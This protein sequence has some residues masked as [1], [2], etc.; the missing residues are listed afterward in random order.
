MNLVIMISITYYYFVIKKHFILREI[1]QT[2]NTGQ[3]DHVHGSEKSI[4][5]RYQLFKN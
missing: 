2:W 1:Q 4:F 5:L 3:I